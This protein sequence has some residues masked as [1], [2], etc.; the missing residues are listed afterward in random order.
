MKDNEYQCAMCGKV[1]KKGVP[2]EETWAEHDRNFP[3]EPHETAAVVC[4]DC[5]KAM[6]AIRPPPGMPPEKWASIS[7]DRPWWWHI[8]HPILSRKMK[9]WVAEFEAFLNTDEEREKFEKMATKAIIDGILYGES[10]TKI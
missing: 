7:F 6:V 1:Y 2:D 8:L 10:R 3:G 4:D 9:V 5:Y